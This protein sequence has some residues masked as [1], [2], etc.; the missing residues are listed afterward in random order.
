M[1]SLDTN[2]SLV[3]NI[4]LLLREQTASHSHDYFTR[5][6]LRLAYKSCG[7]SSASSCECLKVL[8]VCFCC[9]SEASYLTVS[10]IYPPPPSLASRRELQL[11]QLDSFFSPRL[12]RINKWTRV[13]FFLFSIRATC[14]SCRQTFHVTRRLFL[15]QSLRRNCDE[16]LPFITQMLALAFTFCLPHHSSFFFSASSTIIF[17]SSSSSSLQ[18]SLVAAAPAA[19]C[20]SY[21][22]SQATLSQATLTEA[23]LTCEST[24]T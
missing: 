17:L 11:S 7:I 18:V 21:C 12:T 14:P 23:C 9:L 3:M 19:Y 24:T 5:T 1:P 13:P 8:C 4:S 2:W 15:L 20:S 16:Y 22:F 10:M 6:S